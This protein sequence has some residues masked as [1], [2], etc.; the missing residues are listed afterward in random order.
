M[1]TTTTQPNRAHRAAFLHRRWEA[2]SWHAG[3]YGY[4]DSGTHALP[5][6]LAELVRWCENINKIDAIMGEPAGRPV[7]DIKS[8]SQG[9]DTAC[10]VEFENDGNRNDGAKFCPS[11]NLTGS[12]NFWGSK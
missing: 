5:S 6:T 7:F 1:S 12:A 2:T 9:W 11:L 8:I 10:A 4:W 3:W